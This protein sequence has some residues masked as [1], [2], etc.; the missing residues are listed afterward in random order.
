[1]NIVTPRKKRHDR[2]TRRL[3]AELLAR[4][5]KEKLPEVEITIAHSSEAANEL[6]DRQHQDLALVGMQMTGCSGITRIVEVK[7]RLPPHPLPDAG[8]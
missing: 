4:L 7:A 1:M 2:R 8:G 5:L 3:L 6:L